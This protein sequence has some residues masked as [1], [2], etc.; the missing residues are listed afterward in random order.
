M[1]KLPLLNFLFTTPDLPVST[2]Q[3]S[4]AERTGEDN[5]GQRSAFVGSL[6]SWLMN[7]LFFF[8]EVMP[9]LILQSR[10]QD[11]FQICIV[12]KK[13]QKERTDLIHL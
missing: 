11:V 7:I 6:S 9:T 2:V 5:A 1:T 13:S 10:T 12:Q 4:A 8:K 3:G